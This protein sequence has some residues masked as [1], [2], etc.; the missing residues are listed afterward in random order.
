MRKAICLAMLLLAACAAFAGFAKPPEGGAANS[1]TPNV[2]ASSVHPGGY[3]VE[4]AFDGDPKTRWASRAGVSEPEWLEIDLGRVVGIDGLSIAWEAAYAAE[5]EIRV[6]ED[7]KTWKTV[8]R[9]TSGKGGVER[10]TG[11]A[12][13]GQLVRIHCIKP[14]PHPLYSIWEVSFIGGEAEAA[15]KESIRAAAQRRQ[16]ERAER[17]K[18]IADRLAGQGIEEI[19]FA[20]R[21][22]GGDGHWYANFGYYA[23]G[24]DRK[25][26]GVPG[27]RLSRMNLKTGQIIH[28]ID[29]AQ[30]SVRDP[31]V[32]YDGKR[33]IFAYR[34]GGT[35]NFN[36][37]EI[38]ADGTGLRQITSGPW[39]D[40]EPTWLPD[41]GIAFVSS[42]CKRWVNC[43]LTQVAIIHRCDADG[44]NIRILSSNNEQDN[45]PW[46][47]PDGRILYQRW[48]Y[49]DRS[50]VDY[51]HLWTMNPDGSGQTVFYGN[52]H[53]GIVMIDAKPI[54]NTD[55]VLAIFSPGT[56]SANTKARSI[57][58]MPKTARTIAREQR[59]SARPAAIRIPLAS[60]TFCTPPA[61]AFA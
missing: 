23:R 33:I 1:G 35:E 52:Q 17:F 59:A 57:P 60:S 46:V 13:R 42:R 12:T 47:L 15:I 18:G 9:R 53:P 28:L 4:A 21:H 61:A 51:H 58:L 41:G 44:S 8:N 45:T 56:A 39:D 11:L 16:Q 2:R 26:Y 3:P 7:G 22:M 38:N 34:K 55:K 36:L 14:G 43:W 27:G 20:A 5:Y 50:Q 6:S 19:V 29:D 31:A 49:V 30:G 32:H 40:F 24:E 37:Y 54:P 10:I 48:E 25:A